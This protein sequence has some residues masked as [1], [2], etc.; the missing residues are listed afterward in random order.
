MSSDS[1]DVTSASQDNSPPSQDFDLQRIAAHEDFATQI[2][3]AAAK[4]K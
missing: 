3:I 2:A 1:N 4:R